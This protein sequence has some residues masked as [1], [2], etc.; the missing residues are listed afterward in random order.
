MRI[1]FLDT[2]T[3]RKEYS[4]PIG[5]ETIASYISNADVELMSVEL[6]GYENVI[7]QIKEKRYEII[8]ISAKIGSFKLVK[9]I[10]EDIEK[11]LSDTVICIGDIY[12]TYAYKEIL[13]WNKKIICMIGEG[14]KNWPIL[15]DIVKL[16]GKDYRG[17]LDALQ[18][19]AYVING[20]VKVKQRE[21]VMDVTRANHPSRNLLGDVRRKK[22]IA[23]LEASRGCIYGKCS[24]CGIVQKY[25]NPVW[26]PFP[27]EFIL[28]ELIRL[29]DSGIVSPY[30][31]DEDFFGNDVERVERIAKGIIDLKEN[32]RLNPELNFYFNMRVDSV[33][34]NG[35]IGYKK[36]R[37][38]L[39]LLK[40]AG[41]REVFI[42]IESGSSEQI[43]RYKKNNE[44]M[45]SIKAVMTLNSLSI[46]ADIGFILFD[47]YMKLE[48]LIANLD[49]IL[50]SGIS[51]NYSRLAKKLRVEP[52]TPYAKEHGNAVNISNSLDMETVSFPYTFLDDRIQ[53]IYDVFCK[54][55]SEDLDFIYNLQSLCR[56]EVPSEEARYN[57]KNIIAMYRS[58]DLA[59][60]RKLSEC[61][62]QEC[63]DKYGEVI[64]YFGKLRNKYDSAMMDTVTYYIEKYRM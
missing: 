5:I 56:G 11:Y 37:E 55:E 1:L 10:V 40:K 38:V 52:L 7:A 16:Y 28:E 4:E 42:G 47:P 31:T 63:I 3:I 48:D 33:V 26:R 8:G 44:Q 49:F 30:F 29:S 35:G 13:K 14:E 43:E 12:G 50:Q 39:S 61:E 2:G 34:G 6:N 9:R 46:D 20:E 25:G 62:R 27:E 21:V 32:K 59:F 54:W 58:L 17:Y 41:L 19:V 23:H 22:G 64:Q 15:V 51:S 24:F 57:I 60:L 18:S 36:A 53:R 45:K